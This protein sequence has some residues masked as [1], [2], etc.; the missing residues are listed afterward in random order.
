[1]RVGIIGTGRMGSAMVRGLLRFSLSEINCYDISEKSLSNISSLKGVNVI[2]NRSELI[3]NSDLVIIAV[4]PDQVKDAL[5]PQRDSS[6]IFLSIVAGVPLSLIN[7]LIGHD[8]NVRAMPNLAVETGNGIIG[9]Y[10]EKEDAFEKVKKIMSPLGYFFRV[11]KEELLDAVT[12]TGGSSPAFVALFL[13]SLSDAGVLI[14]LSREDSFNIALK[15]LEGT[16]KLISEKG[17]HPAYFQEMVSSPG[18]TTIEGLSF[19]EEKGFKGL[20]MEA[21]RR[22]YLKTQMLKGR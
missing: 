14:G 9:V 16:V 7:E 17:I 1:M 8:N 19:L 21:V 10:G 12:A 6:K 15:V 20:V 3:K 2:K 4:K 22:T 11:K 18:G 13:E 5:E